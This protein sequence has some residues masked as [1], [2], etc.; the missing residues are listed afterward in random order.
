MIEVLAPG[1]YIFETPQGSFV[2]EHL[3]PSTDYSH[4]AKKLLDG[5]FED[6]KRPD[7]REVMSGFRAAQMK[8]SEILAAKANKGWV[9]HAEEA[10]KE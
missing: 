8:L 6:I 10:N 7:G 1:Y 4:L 5:P 9:Q 2:V 3:R